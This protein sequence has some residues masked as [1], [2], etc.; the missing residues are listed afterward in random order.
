MFLARARAEQA[1]PALGISEAALDALLAYAWPGNVR[2]LKNVVER[3]SVLCTG[4]RLLPEHLPP[5]LLASTTPRW[6]DAATSR[7]G[8]A[9]AAERQTERPPPRPLDP[10]ARQQIL[11]ALERT[12]GN[13]TRAAELLGISRRTLVTRLTDFDIPRPRKR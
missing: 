4:D 6:P 3:G 10:A 12:A 13:Q 5:K 8:S 2:E 11:D 9:A 1:A 7:T